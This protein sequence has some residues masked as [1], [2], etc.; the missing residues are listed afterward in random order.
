MPSSQNKASLLVFGQRE[1]G[2]LVS[3]QVVAACTVIEVW[4]GSELPAM[5]IAMAVGT[6]LECNFVLRVSTS[7]DMALATLQRCMSPAQWVIRQLM[8]LEAER[9]RFPAIHG[10]AGSTLASVSAFGELAAVLVFVTI[11]ALAEHQRFLEV[12]SGVAGRTFNRRM[13]PEQWKLRL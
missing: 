6:V 4:R 3:I 5:L 9:R 7:W 8:F 12:A 1:C 10:V 13:L 11:H 2:G